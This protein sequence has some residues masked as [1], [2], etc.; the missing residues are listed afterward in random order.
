ML[1]F[2]QCNSAMNTPKKNQIQRTLSE[3]QESPFFKYANTSLSP[4]SIV[5]KT[6]T[7][8]DTLNFN[9]ASPPSV[10]TLPNKTLLKRHQH[11]DVA[12]PVNRIIDG[13]PNFA[14]TENIQSVSVQPR[15]EV[16]SG[17]VNCVKPLEKSSECAKLNSQVLNNENE[18][19]S[20][21]G[22]LIIDSLC[23]VTTKASLQISQ[24]AYELS[25]RCLDVSSNQGQTYDMQNPFNVNDMNQTDE[26]SAN[27]DY[28]L[29]NELLSYDSN[30]ITPNEIYNIHGGMQRQCLTFE[31]PRTKKSTKSVVFSSS[32]SS[33]M[34][35]PLI[36]SSGLFSLSN[37]E[38]NSDSP[39]TKRKKIETTGE[40][41]ACNRCKC[42]KSKCLKLYCDCFAAGVYC[43]EPCSCLDC[44]NKPIYE[45]TVYAARKQIESRN[46]Q[47]FTP[48]VIKT[49]NSSQEVGLKNSA[50]TPASARHKRGCNCRKSNCLKK[51][52]ECYQ[53]GVGCSINCRCEGC[54]NAFGR[55]DVEIEKSQASHESI[56]N[57][58][59]KIHEFHDDDCQNFVFVMPMTPSRLHR[60]SI[61]QATSS[62]GKPPRSSCLRTMSSSFGMPP[63]E[64]VSDEIPKIL[65][66]NNLLSRNSTSSPNSKRISSSNYGNIHRQSVESRSS[67]KH[68]LQSIP[69]FPS[70]SPPR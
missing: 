12:K 48:K 33:T 57:T 22:L 21:D 50:Q 53:A 9:S 4:L 42:K 44:F 34:Q 31:M 20:C 43:A 49:T 29:V 38:L 18:K 47:A 8:Y 2:I 26:T 14:A 39:K 70:L 17:N 60:R 30:E 56:T 61:P 32:F 6:P 37:E 66:N 68:I 45:E 25:S 27:L 63:V 55:K 46:S 65:Q 1:Y 10:F 52:C 11:P 24:E 64:N 40:G 19:A 51:Y 13:N 69:S 54:K 67:R 35:N 16:S 15:I 7:I 58:S 28:F 62:K 41:I 36:N 59:S 5:K 23:N 3:L